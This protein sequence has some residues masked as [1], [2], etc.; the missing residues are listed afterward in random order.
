MNTIIRASTI[1]EVL[2]AIAD[3][4]IFRAKQTLGKDTIF[5]MKSDEAKAAALT[6]FADELS[7]VQIEKPA[8]GTPEDWRDGRRE[9][10]LDRNGLVAWSAAMKRYISDRNRKLRDES[11]EQYERRMAYL[12]GLETQITEALDSYGQPPGLKGIR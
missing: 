12:R 1:Q 11:V 5:K 8:T 6:E 2:K 3:L 9:I 4:A 7:K 10:S